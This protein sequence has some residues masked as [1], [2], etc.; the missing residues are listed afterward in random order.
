MSSRCRRFRML[1]GGERGKRSRGE[2][3]A[4]LRGA[5]RREN[6]R[7]AFVVHA[8]GTRFRCAHL[9]LLLALFTHSVSA[10]R[11]SLRLVARCVSRVA[12]C[13]LRVARGR[14][15]WEALARERLLDWR[16]KF[17]GDAA[18]TVLELTGDVTPDAASLKRADVIVTTPEKWDGITR[19]QQ[20]C[21]LRL[22]LSRAGP[23]GWHRGDG[24]HIS[25]CCGSGAVVT[26]AHAAAE[27]RHALM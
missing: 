27:P 17:V 9:S 18:L 25:A 7:L 13:D 24:G 3:W 10:C 12:R 5:T 26:S 14:L 19:G 4:G 16:T 20:S 23:C 6:V 21:F 8:I 1:V 2:S 15:F 11:R 22:L